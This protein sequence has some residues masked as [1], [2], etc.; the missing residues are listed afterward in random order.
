MSRWQGWG[1]SARQGGLGLLAG[2]ALAGLLG[3]GRAPAVRAQPTAAEATGLIALTTQ[4]GSSGASPV[5]WL[6]LID[7]RAR[8]FAVYRVDPKDP[9][10]AVKLEATRRYEYDLKL[11]EFNNQAPDVAA[12]E[13]MVGGHA[14]H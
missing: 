10:G 5:Q 4:A 11:A 12:I 3:I 6:Y 14:R 9:K 8:S 1:P 13:A 2:L 7:T